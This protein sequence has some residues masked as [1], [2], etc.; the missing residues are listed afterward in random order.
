MESN[1]R[2]NSQKLSSAPVAGR[3]TTSL[4]MRNSRLTANYHSERHVQNSASIHTARG[5]FITAQV[6]VT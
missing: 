3:G 6:Y 2:D 4:F 5:N 1:A